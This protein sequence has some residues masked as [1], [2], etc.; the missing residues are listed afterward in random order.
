MITWYRYYACLIRNERHSRLWPMRSVISFRPITSERHSYFFWPII[1]GIHTV[2]QSGRTTP[3]FD[4]SE[5]T[6]IL[7]TSRKSDEKTLDL[8]KAATQTFDTQD[9]RYSCLRPIKSAVHNFD[10]SEQVVQTFDQSKVRAMRLSTNQNRHL[11]RPEAVIQNLTNVYRRAPF[12][13]FTPVKT[14]VKYWLFMLLNNNK[15]ADF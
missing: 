2:G 5:A 3:F 13:L 11:T 6:P 14:A 1:S 10:R 7:M 15:S 8:L 4:Q 12:M 9:V